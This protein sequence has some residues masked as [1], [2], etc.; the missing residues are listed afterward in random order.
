MVVSLDVASAVVDSEV[1]VSVVSVAFGAV[2]VSSEEVLPQDAKERIT[3]AAKMAE[4]IF[5][6][7]KSNL[8]Y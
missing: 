8:S 7:V 6:M 1:V 5:F 2:V 4:M 3:A